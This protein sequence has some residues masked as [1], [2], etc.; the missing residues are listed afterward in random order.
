[1]L[2][3][4]AHDLLGNLLHGIARV[5]HHIGMPHVPQHRV[6]VHRVAKRHHVRPINAVVAQQRLQPRGL[7]DTPRRDVDPGVARR[8]EREDVTQLALEHVD[9]V[10]DLV[11]TVVADGRLDNAHV[12]RWRVKDALGVGQVLV[13]LAHVVALV[14]EQ[15]GVRAI[16]EHQVEAVELL[17]RAEEPQHRA[18]REDLAVK[19][20]A[21][22]VDLRA[23]RRHVVHPVSHGLEEPAQR[24]VPAP[25]ARAEDDPALAQRLDE[26]E[27]LLGDLSVPVE[28]GAV[29][30][31]S[32]ET[33]H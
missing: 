12:R 31:G 1:M 17:A 5:A 29:H 16:V 4:G 20:Y 32:D 19:Q 21:V 9:H 23:K 24:L 33:Y 26:L 14:V 7:A 28:Q 13:E 27:G 15:V 3:V 18:R 30:V 10:H 2:D 22:G 6:V 25:G 11:R 8:H